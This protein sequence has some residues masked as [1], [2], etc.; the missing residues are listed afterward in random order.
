MDG[1]V[2]PDIS[3]P[4]FLADRYGQYRILRDHFPHLRTEFDGEE[5]IVITR[6]ADVE[7]VLKNPHATMQQVPGKFPDELLGNGPAALF[8][9]ESLASTD[10]PIHTITRRIMAPAFLP[11][12]VAATRAHVEGIVERYLKKLENETIIEFVSSFASPVTSEVASQ[13]AH[14]P[15]E[16]GAKMLA[17]APEILGVISAG[18]KT[19]DVIAKANSAAAFCY[20]HMEQVYDYLKRQRLPPNDPAAV[21]LVSEGRE[22][23]LTRSRIITFLLGYMFAGYHTTNNTLVDAVVSLLRDRDQ[24]ARLVEHPELAASAWEEATRHNGALHFRTRYATAPITVAG[25]RIEQGRKM[26][27][28]LQSANRDERQFHDPD[29]FIVDRGKNRH[30]GFGSGPHFCLGAQVARLE[31]QII[32]EKIFRRFPKMEIV[33]V[34]RCMDDLTFPMVTRLTLSMR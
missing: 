29:R 10:A 11:G 34:E 26:L 32:L 22:E 31:G 18:R 25:K 6:Y 28:G 20:S 12:T 7:A 14:V 1:F 27:L 5:T 13:L 30:L 21:L 19:P 15:I 8:Y 24:R 33:D 23:C 16:I 17:K 4:E 3:S 9:R 2:A